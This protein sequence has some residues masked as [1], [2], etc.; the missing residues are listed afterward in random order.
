[1]NALAPVA[2]AGLAIAAAESVARR[3]QDPLA[4]DLS[5]DYSQLPLA[6]QRLTPQAVRHA[7]RIVVLGDSIPFG[8]P[9]AAHDGY[10]ARLEALLRARYPGRPLAVINSSIG[11]HTAVMALARVERDLV[12]WRPH[13]ALLG[14]GL[15]DCHL[16]RTALDERRERAMYR[17]Q[18]LD[19]RLRA[20]LRRSALLVLLRR[21]L[22]PAPL[23]A[24][25]T[26][27]ADEA[28]V[29]PGHPRVSPLAY[30]KALRSLVR[31][32]RRAGA[33]PC[34]LTMTPLGPAAL[35]ATPGWRLDIYQAFDALLR[36]VAAQ[37]GA[38]LI[39]VGAAFPSGPALAPLLAR[40]GV[41]LTAQGQALLAEAIANEL[42]GRYL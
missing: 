40:D 9:L 38:A 28:I 42:E 39:D 26:A 27:T 14:F 41:H 34:L 13:I 12:R 23:P 16:A 30:A 15:N 24:R 21:A 18:R 1:M 31:Q 2:L 22:R 33:R 36:Q 20:L 35:A 3:W 37:E 32:A 19:G 10:P 6:T 11:G 17:Q 29:A 8:W 4:R 7:L 25:R 5:G